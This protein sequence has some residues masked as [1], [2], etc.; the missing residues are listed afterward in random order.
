MPDLVRELHPGRKAEGRFIRAGSMSGDTDGRSFRR[1]DSR[2]KRSLALNTSRTLPGRHSL[3]R[4]PCSVPLM[5]GQS[6]TSIPRATF[7]RMS[8]SARGALTSASLTVSYVYGGDLHQAS[9]LC[10]AKDFT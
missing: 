4:N 10:R 6:S 9:M 8:T 1:L 3:V 2:S 7:Q 5:K